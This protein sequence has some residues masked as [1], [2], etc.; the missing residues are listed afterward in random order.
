MDPIGFGFENY[1]GVGRFRDDGERP[2]GRRHRRD[3]RHR[4]RAARSTA[5][6][7]SGRSWRAS[8]DARACVATQWFRYGYGRAETTADGCTHEALHERFAG[9]GY[10]VL[11]L[12]VALTATD[13]FRYRRVIARRRCQ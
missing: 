12:L 5:R 8:E 1:D 13:A 9:T 11:D 2:A 6:S 7:S 4:R 3:R 10:Q